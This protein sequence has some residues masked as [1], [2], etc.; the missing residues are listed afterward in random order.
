MDGNVEAM[1]GEGGDRHDIAHRA[2]PT[3]ADLATRI[4]RSCFAKRGKLRAKMELR[5]RQSGPRGF[6]RG[7]RWLA[8]WRRNNQNRSHIAERRRPQGDGYRRSAAT[9]SV[10]A[11]LCEARERRDYNN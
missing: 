5:A 7:C 9:S 1:L 3:E 2:T 10:A 6:G 4:L 8:V 11:S